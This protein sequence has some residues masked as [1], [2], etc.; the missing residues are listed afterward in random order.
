MRYP[1]KPSI[2]IA[3]SFSHPFLLSSTYD[4]EL[5]RNE[6]CRAMLSI[7]ISAPAVTQGFYRASFP[8]HHTILASALANVPVGVT[9]VALVVSAAVSYANVMTRPHS[10]R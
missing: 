9:L 10:Y 2:N 3:I 1:A 6:A 8:K 5:V 7:A 4:T